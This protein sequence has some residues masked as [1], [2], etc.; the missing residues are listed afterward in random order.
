MDAVV[1]LLALLV[2]AAGV[3]Y[4]YTQQQQKR[5]EEE[6]RIAK[7]KREREE[8]ERLQQLQ[9]KQKPKKVDKT[10]ELKKKQSTA[11]GNNAFIDESHPLLLHV[12]KGH[13]LAITS[14]AYS[15]N[16]RFIATASSDRTVRVFLRESLQDAK[17]KPH[18][19]TLEYDH[20]TALNFS[21]DGRTL[22]RM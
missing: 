13:K 8:A 17:A 1:L 18:V 21:S 11:E 19:I 20:A 22:V 7:E 14:A 2:G 3:F 16:G 4:L 6:A 15:P 12:L 10:A 5:A 9:K